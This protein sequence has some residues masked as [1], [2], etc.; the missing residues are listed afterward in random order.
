MA[1]TASA[2][3]A[4][5]VSKRRS[6]I[7]ALNTEAFRKANKEV[8]SAV[9]KGDVKTAKLSLKKAYSKIDMAIKKH[10]IHKN[11]GSRMK[12]RLAKAVKKADTIK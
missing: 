6:V 7:N 1:N 4:L 12:S 9:V 5:R 8:V 11:T 2:K 10:T 3:K